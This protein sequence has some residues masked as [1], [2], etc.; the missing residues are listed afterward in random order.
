M[1]LMR[2]PSFG[3]TVYSSI[4]GLDE[5]EGGVLS[6]REYAIFEPEKAL[7]R[8]LALLVGWAYQFLGLLVYI[9]LHPCRRPRE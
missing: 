3:G 1:D 5:S 8:L 7:H 4:V 9:R 2:Q 6:L